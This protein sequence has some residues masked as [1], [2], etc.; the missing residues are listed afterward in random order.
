MLLYVSGLV[1]GA[2]AQVTA[3][4]PVFGPTT[5]TRTTGAPNQYTTTFTAPAWITSPYDLHIVNGDSSGK[6]RVYG[7][8]S[9]ATITLNGVQ[10]A[11]PSDFNQ[12]VATLDRSVTLQATNTLQVSL[13]S[14]PGS[15][16]TINV[17][18]TNADHTPPQITIVSPNS[19]GYINTAT[20]TIEV[21]Y[22]DPV[23]AGEPAASGVNT[24]TVK[25][26]LDGVDRTSLF[27]VRAA[28]ASAVIPANLA[29]SAGP[30][31]LI[32]SLQDNAGNPAT[33]TSQ[34]TV[35][36]TAPQI[37]IVQPVLGVYLNTTTPTISIQY[38]DS[39]G[40][41]L[42]TL[43]VLINGVN[44]TPLFNKTVNGATAAISLPQG[45]NQVVAQIQ[46][47]A[48]TQASASTSFNVDTTPPTISFSSPLANSYQASS[49]VG[50]TVQYADDQA[51]DITKLK[52]TVDGNTVSTT[53]TATSATATATNLS[54]A[55]HTLVATIK[56][57]AGNV[58]TVQIT[59]Y[60]DTTVPSVTVSNPAPNAIVST[61]TPQVSVAYA[62]VGGV[63]TSTLK[64]LVNGVDRTGLFSI[65]PSIATAQ[66][67]GAASLADGSNTITAQISNNA[68][69]VGS[70]TSTFVV[71][72]TP[73]TLSFQAP[74]AKINSNTPT[75]TISYSD[76]G[77]GVNPFSLTLSVDGADVSSLVAPGPSSATGVLQLNPP[78]SDGTHQLSATIADRAGNRSQPAALS[79]VVDTKP[80][81]LTFASPSNN[82]F[83]NNPTP[84]L[85]LKYNDGTGTGVDVS[86]VHIQL[87]QGANLPTDITSD[88]QIGSQ[89]ATGAIPAASL[90]ADGTYVLTAVVSDLVGNPGSA[91][92]TFVVDTVPPTATMQAP[93]A[94]AILNTSVP[95]VV[96]Q[97]SDSNSGVDTSKVVLTVD[98]VNQTSILTLTA[99]QATGTLPT[100]ADGVHT[101]QL[102]VFDRAGNSS[103]VVSQTFTTDTTAPTIAV[104]VLPPPNAAGWN[105]TSVTV[106]FTCFD[107]GSG[108]STCPAPVAVASEGANQSFCGQAIDAAGNS[109]LPA[110]ATVNIDKT[111]P[112]ITASPSPAPNAAGWN[113]SSVTVTFICAD[114]LSGVAAC[115]PAQSIATPGAN[116][117]VKGTA[118]DL[119]GNSASTQI[120]VN[121]SEV[122]PQIIAVAAPLP[123][124]AGWNN[125]NVVV[126]FTCTPA[127]GAAPITNCPTPQL[128]STEGASI[129]VSGTVTDA[130]GATATASALI[131]LD[132]TPP[133]VIPN[134]SPAPNSNGWETAPVTV[135]FTCSDSLSG[136]ATCPASTSISSD[137]ANQPVSGSATDLAGNTTTASANVN[138][139]QAPPTISASVS[140]AANSAGWNN[141]NVTVT[142]ACS[143]SASPISS[144]SPPQTVSSPGSGQV[145]TGTVQDQA[146]KQNTASVTLNIDETPPSILQFTAPTQLSPGQSGPATLTVNDIAAV[147]SVVFQLNGTPIGTSLA[148]PYTISVTAPSTAISGSTLTLTAVVTDVAGNASSASKGIQVV[149]SGVIVGQVLSDATGL[150]LPGATL[151][152]VGQ[153]GEGA[154]S[155]S[156]G[157]YSIPV[158]SN[159]LFLSAS[160][161][162][163]SGGTPAMVTVERQVSVQTGVGTVPVDARLTAVAA[164]TTVTASG[165]TVG[166]GSI[167]VTVPAGGATAL[168]NLTPLSPQ[169][170]PGLLPLGWSP[171]AAFDLRTN[172]SNSAALSANFTGLPSGI[173][174][175]TSY[176][177]NVHGWTMVAP[178][179]ST[180]NGSLTVTL[181]ATG[182]YALVV[183][184]AGNASIQIPATGQP[185]T[186]VQM[187][188]LPTNATSSGS[189]SPGNIAPTGGTST[190]SLAVQS[191]VPLPSGT[192]IQS[193]VTETYTLASGQSLSEEPRFEDILLYQNPAG[194]GG[195]VAASFPVTPSQIF[196][197]SQ[198]SSGDVHMDIL[199]GRE[200]V[201]GATGGSDPVAVQS[202]DATLT[203]AAGS[204]AQDT[205]IA[206]TPETVDAFL[207]STSSFVPISEYN[208]DFS[209]QVLNAA[210]QLSVGLG[211]AVPGSNVVI[212]QIQRVGGVPFLVAVGM[213][214]V[215]ATNIVSQVTPGLPGITQGGDYVFYQLSVP[216]GLV[217]GTV[218]ASSGPVAA[219]IQTDA[220]PFIAFSNSNGNY[221]IAAATGTVH[222]SA[223]IPNTALAGTATAQVTTG[224]TATA[225]LTVTGQVESA[226]ITPANGAV[227]V[228]LTAE[229]DITAADAFNTATVTPATVVLTAAGSSTPIAL[230]FIFSSGGSKLAIFPQVALQ[231]ST[232]YT[233]QG[234]G[235][236]NA[237][238]GLISIPTTSFTTVAITAP[239]YNT[240]ALVFA[241]PDSNGNVAVSAPAN[242]FPAGSTILI[243]D[244]TNGVVYSLTVFNDGSVTGQMPATINDILQV[245]L[246]DPSGIKTTFTVSQFVAADGTTA[247][248]AGGGTVIGPGGTGIIIPP[249]A[250]N[251]GTTFK[252]TPLDQSAFPQLPSWA[253]SNFGSGLRISDPSM[254]TFN[255]EAK[256]AFPVPPNAPSNAFY[257]VYRRLVD[258]NGKVYFETIDHAFV[259]GTGANARVVTASPPFCGYHNSFGNF[260]IVAD[261]PPLPVTS[262]DQDYF[263]MWDDTAQSGPSGVASQG[264]IVGLAQQVVPAVIG[265]SEATTQPAQG[266]ITISLGSNVAIYDGICAT[267]TL[268]DP[269]LG[270]GARTVTASNGTT[271]LQTT[272][273]EVDGAQSDDGLYAI[274]AG[275]EDLYKNIGRAN[276][277]FPAPVLPPPP[278]QISIRLF[279]LDA[280]GHRVA[281]GGILQAGTNVV[282]AF[283]SGL[284]V[285]SASIGQTQLVVQTPDS[286]NSEVTDGLP[287]QN[288]LSARVQQ[289]YTVGV[290]GNYTI[291]A[292]AVDPISLLQVTVTQDILVVA[293]GGSDNTTF[294]CTAAPPPA[295]PTLGCTL[296]MVVDVSPTNYSSGIPNTVF[297]VVTFN[298]PVTNLSSGNVV[299]ACAAPA[300]ANAT[301][302]CSVG[303]VVPVQLV[304]IRAPN[305]LNPNQNPIADPVQP[306]DVITSLTVQ[307]V[308]G[309]EYSQTYSLTLNANAP[310]GCLNDKGNPAPQPAGTSLIID[311][312]KAPTGPLCL[313]PYGVGSQSYS[314]T[315]FGPQHLGQVDSHNPVT[316]RPVVL[317]QIAYAGEY[318]N[319]SIGGLGMFNVSN[320]AAPADLGTGADFI[321]RAIDIAGQTKS[322]VTASGGGLVAI[323]AGTAVD[324]AIPA[325]VWLYDVSSPTQPTRVGAVSV[326][327]DTT[328]GIATRLFMKD[329]YLYANVFLQGLQV[330]DL[331]QALTE[332]QQVYSQNP[333]QFGQAVSTSG[334]GFAMD[335]IVNTIPLPVAVNGQATGGGAMMLDLKADDFATGSGISQTLVVAAGQ[336]PF[337]MVDP[338]LSGS[339]A[340]LYPPNSG[341]LFA[342]G[343]VKPLL[344]TSQDGT[345][346]YLLCYGQALDVGNIATTNSNG[347][348]ITEHV[349]VVVGTGLSGS[350]GSTTSCPLPSG[351]SALHPVLAVVDIS[352]IYNAPS[353]LTPKLIGFLPLSSAGTDVTLNGSVALVSTGSNIL[354]VNLENPSQPIAAGTIKGSFG[355]WLALTPAGFMI[356][357]SSASQSGAL[358]TATSEPV[359]FT[360]CPG[361]ILSSVVS[362]A[363]T[364]SAVYRTVQ[365]VPCTIYVVPSNTAA[366]TASVSFVQTNPAIAFNNVPLSGGMAPVVFPAGTQ[367]TGVTMN[368]ISSA[369]NSQTGVPILNLTQ[370][371]PVGPVHIVVDSDNDTIIDP[372]T[373][374]AAA[375][376]GKKFSFWQAD[377]KNTGNSGQDGLLDYAPLRVYVNAVPSAAEGSIQLVLASSSG[378][379]N[380]VL[381]TNTGVLDGSSDTTAAKNEKRYLTDQ[382][383][384]SSEMNYTTAGAVACGANTGNSFKSSL[385]SSD[386]GG[387]IELPNLQT[388]VMYD[389]LM[390]CIT[391]AQDSSWILQS[392]LVSPSGTRTVLDQVPVDI[393]PLQKWMTIETVRN[394]SDAKPMPYPTVES[395]WM[396]IPASAQNLV[397]LVHGFD[398]TDS[399][400]TTT[401]MPQWFK[402]LYWTGHPVLLAQNNT[403]TVGLTWPGDPGLL[404]FTQYPIAYMTALETGVP[405]AKFLSDQSLHY[406]RKIQAIAH[407]LGN[408]VMNSALS[409]P[410]IQG[411][412]VTTYVM[413][414]PALPAEAFNA[415]YQPSI[416]ENAFFDLHALSLGW[417][418]YP[419]QIPLDQLWQSE[420]NNATTSQRQQWITTLST[421]NYVTSPQPSYT[422]RWAQQRPAAGVPDSA[423]FNS[424]P[425]R[426]SWLGFFAGN[427][428]KTTIVNTYNYGDLTLL[429]WAP[430]EVAQE[431]YVGILGF[432]TDDIDTQ[433][434]STLASTD[435]GQ[436]T[437]W[438]QACSSYSNCRHSNI[439]RQWAELSYWFPSRSTAAGQGSLAGMAN[440]NFGPYAPALG[441]EATH[442]FLKV[443]PY[444]KVFPAWQDINTALK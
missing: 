114:T 193:K 288:L 41:N 433:F 350:A 72:T 254:P 438:S 18:G 312:N 431:P 422:L 181:P 258:Q 151:Q 196:Q 159:Q 108:V 302:S 256:L 207:P 315:T 160:Q 3:S 308:D 345:T 248:G 382:T 61:H 240:N 363:G 103:S 35:D 90:L 225:N 100:L 218:S 110:C 12:N 64:V 348:S 290:P 437:I 243:V 2:A 10:I 119:A 280:K 201:R 264:L 194:I 251:Q 42:S 253:G 141:T 32:I 187:V 270:G 144:C 47:L 230:R 303:S 384:A 300:D 149:S 352:Q 432:S 423:P 397:L 219:T 246:T 98:G 421:A 355:N 304:G 387:A 289:L 306:S 293:A 325:N 152:V 295:D 419:S 123:N 74:A 335:A 161:P 176:S 231:P 238:G 235:V 349:A 40:L 82:S 284:A 358:Q 223:S 130:A 356:T 8:I 75:V 85:L 84:S 93:A 213:A 292:T 104:S 24:S 367:I 109:S 50:L 26:T 399:D 226:A 357:T 245:T 163:N 334:D 22:S 229:I 174:Y 342:T 379:A 182:D 416:V 332:Y 169:G 346:N 76:A 208:V 351:A 83:I 402:R 178:N 263:T 171:V 28:D 316:T 154:L 275:L 442:S 56:D 112:T 27:T 368:A 55:A 319:S 89:Q 323:S 435:G 46:N 398:V 177:Y 232:Q 224:Q 29:L 436:E 430:M 39:V 273:E 215:T 271:S 276:F 261:A 153:T 299:L 57:L 376:A 257:Y 216:T 401:F 375:Q 155:D 51:L 4:T 426:G 267:F 101:V 199:S 179:L 313:Q 206:V 214:Q 407:S 115:P 211:S 116:Q 413:N 417:S 162:G 15:F 87:Q 175:L 301:G 117:I 132:K 170:L 13:A 305:P 281:A 378:V 359:V 198:L 185:L 81:V 414:E 204:L 236:A 67:S 250:L 318:V 11:G 269:Q 134:I 126:S 322:P 94:N 118:T 34:F 71:D 404:T 310:M 63:N 366:K 73:P 222:L 415:N 131:K 374:T 31:T 136:V 121:I 53:N 233:V 140:P 410:E 286:D 5:Y 197:V 394:G 91:S 320:P 145:I 33:T 78:L 333:T 324:N 242:S 59:F 287:E 321:G 272:V 62:D 268:F 391:C 96:I 107:S 221:T 362:G 7:A 69:T 124:A 418:D 70:A 392:V 274:Y 372:V 314:F 23:G 52:V 259:Q 340:V 380:W 60:V 17:L 364:Q 168:F 241:M 279:T 381:T 405:L 65:G 409:R 244:Q 6:D 385:C 255:K 86:T 424:T 133:T 19:G 143:Q 297:P 150:P 77:S 373:D 167:T 30:H 427:L 443:G 343:P 247:I 25:A 9:S 227:G 142:F 79:F 37:Q 184:D 95:S 127:P 120:P 45:G 202:G 408:V 21:T 165:G 328:G 122:P 389:L 386:G 294:A 400:A 296:P 331:G 339:S 317:G 412:Q 217:K 192:V 377:P 148:P 129:P 260:K 327:S 38:S 210:A 128:I 102:T 337:V 92:A 203:I 338:T 262:I 291:T 135:S 428:S 434:W 180:T 186:G 266:T 158:T 440:I 139:E 157:K 54:N 283:R 66:L 166:T 125:T 406:S 44:E 16:L 146:G 239:T 390:S 172:V 425:Q 344:M 183:P 43:K 329:Q 1:P 88:F 173:L 190:A 347:V 383:T 370:A 330:I 403:Q 277:L 336:L 105:N 396:D 137:G 365:A 220:L 371:I 147:T 441:L 298:E 97:Y 353:P 429:A 20:P 14:K 113:N 411:A 164:P 361:P 48:G 326:A 209:G 252:L 191:G 36:L 341:G 444:S 369:V 354:L 420:W 278:P 156:L 58:G 188:A 388:G 265:V 249:G 99:T 311:L 189:L 439:I 309:L 138:L 68:G 212:A 234:S 106:T 200:S 307:P 237:L 228:P 282:I 195:A 111:P 360:Q 49:T 393:R 80:P 205:A 285:Q 395:G